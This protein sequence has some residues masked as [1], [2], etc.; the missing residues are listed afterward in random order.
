MCWGDLPA[1]ARAC[2]SS[3]RCDDRL[4]PWAVVR[5]ELI[6]VIRRPGAIVSLVLGP[7]LI[8]AVFGI[9]YSGVRRPLDTVLVVPPDSGLS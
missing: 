7:F 8:M 1:F 2:R 3:A 5:K 6:E 9:G 4:G